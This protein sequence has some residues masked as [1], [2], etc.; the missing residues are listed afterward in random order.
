MPFDSAIRKARG[1]ST[2][3]KQGCRK[4]KYLAH[5]KTRGLP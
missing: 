4:E 2:N 1:K 5:G 3:C